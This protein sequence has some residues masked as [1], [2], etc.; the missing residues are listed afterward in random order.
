MAD[1]T[2][3]KQI[4]GYTLLLLPVTLLLVYPLHVAG[5]LYAFVA[6]VLGGQFIYKAWQLIQRPED[7]QMARSVFKFSILYMMLL[8]ASLGLDS[9][10]WTQ[11]LLA[12]GAHSASVT[13]ELHA[14]VG[15]SKLR[16]LAPPKARIGIETVD[17]LTLLSVAP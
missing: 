12:Q 17:S 7:K 2:T 6:L 13:G 10:P 9:L 16:V 11:T 3:A 4:F 14:S 1:A 8:C 15:G 5:P